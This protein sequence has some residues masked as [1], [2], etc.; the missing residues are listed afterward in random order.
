MR[1]NTQQEVPTPLLQGAFRSAHPGPLSDAL[2][3]GALAAADAF[4]RDAQ[5][6]LLASLPAAVAA[7][8]KIVASV[9]TDVEVGLG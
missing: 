7:R 3:P 5:R 2:H 6:R 4:A 8:V 9:H 1:D